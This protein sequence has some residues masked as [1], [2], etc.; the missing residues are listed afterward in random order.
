[1]LSIISPQRNAN[2]NHMRC[3]LTPPEWLEK[4]SQ[5]I[6][7]CWQVKCRNQ[8]FHTPLVDVLNDGATLVN[9]LAVPQK[10]KHGLTT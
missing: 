6:V 8:N 9:S 1:M 7:R 3:H 5:I 10:L 2:Q 4:K